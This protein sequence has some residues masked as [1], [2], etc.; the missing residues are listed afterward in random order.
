M[1]DSVELADEYLHVR[2]RWVADGTDGSPGFEVTVAAEDDV[3]VSFAL[4]EA[5]PGNVSL[6]DVSLGS[7]RPGDWLFDHDRHGIV[8]EGS[9]D[10]SRPV[11]TGW[12]F[13]N[14][15]PVSPSALLRPP[16]IERSTPT[17][18]IGVPSDEVGRYLEKLE[19][20]VGRSPVRD[21]TPEAGPAGAGESSGDTD[22]GPPVPG[23]TGGRPPFAAA[24]RRS[25][26]RSL[27]DRLDAVETRHAEVLE[28]ADELR[29][30]VAEE[31][32]RRERVADVVRSL[33]EDPG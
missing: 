15:V 5:L 27:G 12:G 10:V 1:A 22:E 14:D 3:G 18:A 11:T 23:D 13:E 8:F 32:R 16:I 26:E 21:G 33:G 6:D 2:K 20:S 24:G 29:S 17:H 9:V 31:R 25:A 19:S 7:V 28:L 4:F 30:L